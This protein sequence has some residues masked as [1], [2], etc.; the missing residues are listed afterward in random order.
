MAIGSGMYMAGISCT[1]IVLLVELFLGRGG[2]FARKGKETREVSVEYGIDDMEKN[3]MKSI[4]EQ[5][6]TEGGKIV[7]TV[8]K[9]KEQ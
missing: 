1:L 6:N 2:A 5:I 7:R 8:I 3:I 9:R 4:S